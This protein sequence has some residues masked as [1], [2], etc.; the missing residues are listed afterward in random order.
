VAAA[1][2]SGGGG[3]QGGVTTIRNPNLSMTPTHLE[4]SVSSLP[5]IGNEER[6]RRLIRSG[7]WLILGA[8]VPL[9]LWLSFA[10]LSTAVIAPAV[11]SVDL[12]RRLVQHL[13]GGT[14]REV[15]VRDGQQVKEGEPLIVLGD[16]R[17][18]AD[19]NRLQ[20]RVSVEQATVARLEAELALRQN[21]TVGPSLKEAAKADARVQEALTKE[22][23]LFH[24]RRHTLNSHVSLLNTQRGKVSDEIAAVTAQIQKAQ[25]SLEFQEKELDTNRGLLKDGFVSPVRI[26]QMEAIVADYEA[27]LEERRT[28]RTRAEQRLV[29]IDLKIK[30]LQNE[31]IKAA[32]DELKIAGTRLSELEQESRKSDDA[33]ERQ[34]ITAPAAGEIIDLK[35]KTPGAMVGPREAI[36]EI[37]PRD[38]KL[39]IE[40]RVRPEDFTHLKV[41]QRAKIQFTGFKFQTTLLIE[42]SVVYLAGDRLVDR[43]TGE[44][45]YSVLIHVDPQSL[46][47]AGGEISLHAGMPA[48]VYIQGNKVTP[49]QYLLEP[50][51][52]TVRRAGRQL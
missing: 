51:T 6:A 21:V 9:G 20:Y 23:A 14:I 24:S 13:D 2:C 18:D 22:I 19:R 16:V 4:N 27:K 5:S 29:D 48:E 37:V 8:I 36:A 28:D 46:G 50:I 7:R 15:L 26:N 39:V 3:R 35:F 12:N 17:V 44:A 38:A 1:Q 30:S 11:V 43:Q 25:Q 10:P 52:A 45:Y 31:Y 49:L 41:G 32:S 42:G 47:S 34:V 33:A 40:S